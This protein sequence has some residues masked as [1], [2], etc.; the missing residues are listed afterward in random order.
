M[1]DSKDPG[2]FGVRLTRAGVRALERLRMAGLPR[3]ATPHSKGKVVERALLALAEA[4][5]IDVT[6]EG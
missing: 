6:V 1:A 3:G 4:E 5:G 2:H